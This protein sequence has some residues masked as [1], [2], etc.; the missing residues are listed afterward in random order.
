MCVCVCVCVCVCECVC[1]C[2]CVCV[3]LCV[4]VCVCACLRVRFKYQNWSE[5]TFTSPL[6]MSHVQC[7]AQ[8]FSAAGTSLCHKVH[9]PKSLVLSSCLNISAMWRLGSLP[10]EIA[11]NRVYLQ[12]M[13]YNMCLQIC[14][15]LV[16]FMK[17]AKTVRTTHT[18]CA[19]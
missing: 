17:S 1:V 8:T 6:L 9:K 15:K 11:C 12:R 16:C 2:V 19:V 7:G 14:H 4:C 5:H 18:C 13:V 10:R 3:C